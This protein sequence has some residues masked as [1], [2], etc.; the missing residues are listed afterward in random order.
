[1]V[2]ILFKIYLIVL[3][4][5]ILVHDILSNFIIVKE[6]CQNIQGYYYSKP[7]PANEYK[8]FL[9]KYQ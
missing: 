6:G 4:I 1:M 8:D 5:N 7:L 9:L 2:S 3:K